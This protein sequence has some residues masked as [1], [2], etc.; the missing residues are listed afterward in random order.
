MDDEMG[1][2]YDSGNLH[3]LKN[4]DLIDMF[5]FGWIYRLISLMYIYVGVPVQLS[6]IYLEV[7][8][9]GAEYSSCAIY[10]WAETGEK[11]MAQL[12]LF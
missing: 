5:R 2:R 12:P 6:A 10:F 11:Y 1:T 4:D 3:F 7:K 8:V 9:P